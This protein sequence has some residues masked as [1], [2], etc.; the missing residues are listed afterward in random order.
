M[1]F[2]HPFLKPRTPGAGHGEAG[3]YSSIHWLKGRNTPWTGHP[4]ITGLTHLFPKDNLHSPINMLDC[5]RKLENQEEMWN[6]TWTPVN[7]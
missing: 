1:I 5:G 4:S 2:I 6:P 7:I 3:A